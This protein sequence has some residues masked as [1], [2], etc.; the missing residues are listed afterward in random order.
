MIE[1][2][3]QKLS[4]KPASDKKPLTHAADDTPYRPDIDGLRAVAVIAVILYHGF[5]TIFTGGFIGVDIFFVISGFLISA[6]IFR[7]IEADHFS[8]GDFYGR[9]IRR[10][11]PS[12]LVILL[13][14][15]AYGF[16]V[17]LPSEL[18]LLGRSIVAGGGF[19]AN[20]LLWHEA[21]YFDQASITKPLLHLWSLGV[22]EQFYI[23]W[24]VALWVFYRR[25]R[26]SPIFLLL[27]WVASLGFSLA[28]IRH[29]QTA[30]FYSPLSR[31]WE[32]DS[33]AILAWI[34]L[35]APDRFGLT[36]A[37]NRTMKRSRYADIIS[38]LGFALIFG[39]MFLINRTM[40][41]PG[42]LAMVP[43]AGA[44][45]LIVAGPT[46]LINRTVLTSRVAVFIGLISYP[47]YLWHWPLIS[48]AYIIDHDRPLKVFL[49]ICLIAL[50]ILLAW[51]TY[52]FVERPLRFGRNRRR[53]TIILVTAMG[54]VGLVGMTAWWA[55]GFPDRYPSL[56]D[57]SVAKINAAI[58]NGIFKPTPGMQV[59]KIDG[60]TVAHLGAGSSAVLFIGD[61]VIFQYGPR[62]QQLLDQGRLKK[63]VYFVVGPSCAPV[64]GV[65]RNGLFAMCNHL[66]S[67]AR[68]VIAQH[69]IK[70]IVIGASWAGYQNGK[71]DI[72]RNGKRLPMN[73]AVAINDFYANLKDE[74]SRL[75][76]SHHRV[77]LVLAPVAN[78]RFDPASMITRSPI[79]FKVDLNVLKGVPIKSLMQASAEVNHR[80]SDIAQ[81]TGAKTLNPLRDV[82]GDGP[83]CSA[84][85][86]HGT[87]KFAD[88]LHLQPD[89]VAHHLK[90][91][92][93]ILTHASRGA[94]AAQN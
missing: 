22:E 32:L 25:R 3:M 9:R 73:S 42:G 47:L 36:G 60:I 4:E 80:L 94:G 76:Q 87:P 23:V 64:P 93:G 72:E 34:T 24:P 43:V 49:V 57:L 81:A 66:Q 56:P 35:Y 62:V 18:A 46:A 19:V 26:T 68:R 12:L 54:A 52:R 86:D 75:V 5:P 78:V 65:I 38:L 90:M 8:F 6:N 74:V 1:T 10:I 7:K 28:I 2:I 51:L 59:R 29:Y 15:L 55:K 37:G 91:F 69:R 83:D 92:D 84:F 70:T 44:L 27:A 77:Y 45:M 71:I 21:G 63:S 82:C 33:G 53:N 13:A 40:P 85:F 48:F 11:F 50:S 17:L 89:F 31:L 88:G 16:I 58:G 41:F 20:L 61:S 14:C 30:D 67:V 39:A 79:G